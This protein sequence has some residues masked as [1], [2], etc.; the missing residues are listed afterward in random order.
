M[1]DDHKLTNMQFN[2]RSH[3]RIQAAVADSLGKIILHLI[4]H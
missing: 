1:L 2:L 4:Y 3:I